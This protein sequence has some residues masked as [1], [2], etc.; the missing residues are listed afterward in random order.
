LAQS[1]YEAKIQHIKNERAIA[2]AQHTWNGVKRAE[3]LAETIAADQARAKSGLDADESLITGLK[4]VF[5]Q[6]K[7][8][9]NAQYEQGKIGSQ[10]RIKLIQAELDADALSGKDRVAAEIE[11]NNLKKQ[12]FKDEIDFE[13]ATGQID[14]AHKIARLKE[15]LTAF[16]QTEEQKR[17][18]IL[19][20]NS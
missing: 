16:Q 2:E 17:Q 5:E 18:T 14:L 7:S 13:E 10:E 1:E 6:N 9:I 4:A 20:I 15:S 8:N 3:S 19:E 12:S 11:I